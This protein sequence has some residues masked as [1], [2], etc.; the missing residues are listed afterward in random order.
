MRYVVPASNLHGHLDME[1]YAAAYPEA[2]L[3]AAPGLADKRTG[4]CFDGELSATSDPARADD[5]DRFSSMG[6][7][8]S[9]RSSSSTV[10]AAR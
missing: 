5:L 10:Q 6:T 7:A 4:L 1:Q 2:R 3:F 9:T 8:C